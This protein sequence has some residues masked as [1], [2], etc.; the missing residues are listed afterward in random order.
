MN[1]S[2]TDRPSLD[3]FSESS[4]GCSNSFTFLVEIKG[5]L[6]VFG[7][8]LQTMN[9]WWTNSNKTK[10]KIVFSGERECVSLSL[11][12]TP[13]VLSPKPS[14]LDLMTYSG[15]RDDVWVPIR[16]L[17]NTAKS[18]VEHYHKTL[19]KVYFTHTTSCIQMLEGVEFFY[20]TCRAF[21]PKRCQ[22]QRIL[23][24]I[25]Y[26]AKMPTETKSGVICL[27]EFKH[28]SDVTSHQV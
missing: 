26:K 16:Q 11:P 7:Y 15:M 21:H 23:N 22:G 13:Y 10:Q 27:L 3:N 12:P 24:T 25:W 6:K 18:N 9:G 19:V 28:M 14:T 4:R 2:T 5:F 8:L 1:I 20:V 17:V